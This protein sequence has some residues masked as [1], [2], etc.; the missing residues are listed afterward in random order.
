MEPCLTPATLSGQRC[1]SWESTQI[2]PG[3]YDATERNNIIYLSKVL[4]FVLI[5]CFSVFQL[6]D[7]SHALANVNTVLRTDLS[8][9]VQK[10]SLFEFLTLFMNSGLLNLSCDDY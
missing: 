9:I 8:N 4:I 3:Y 2:S 5:S 6:P 1:R 7:V 10:V